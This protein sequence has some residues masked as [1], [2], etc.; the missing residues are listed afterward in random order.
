MNKGFDKYDL[1]IKEDNETFIDSMSEL[2]VG[3]KNDAALSQKAVDWVVQTMP[4]FIY[5]DEYPELE[6]HQNIGQYFERKK[7]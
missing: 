7:T 2:I 4:V 6:G 5:V 1:V 3:V